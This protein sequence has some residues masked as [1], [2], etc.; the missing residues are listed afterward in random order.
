MIKMVVL[1][2]Q[3]FITRWMHSFLFGRQK[4]AKINNVTSNWITLN[5][6]IPP[7]LQVPG[8]ASTFAGSR[9][10]H[11]KVLQTTQLT[12]KFFDNATVIEVVDYLCSS[13]MQT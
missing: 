3:S 1:G 12:F 7:V 4:R 13:Q 6:G 2:E 8:L 10:L 5:G 9:K 11:I